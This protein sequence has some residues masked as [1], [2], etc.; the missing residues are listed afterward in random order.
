[1]AAAVLPPGFEDVAWCPPGS[2]LQPSEIKPG[3]TG[4]KSSFVE[5]YDEKTEKVTNE[6]WTGSKSPTTAPEG[7]IKAEFCGQQT[8]EIEELPEE[9]LDQVGVYG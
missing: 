3:H 2:C 9:Y 7:W 8:T 5:C 6:V 1:M 4:A